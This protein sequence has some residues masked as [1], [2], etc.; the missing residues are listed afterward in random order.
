MALLRGSTRGMAVV[1]T[2][3]LARFLSPSQFGLYG[4]AILV[5]GLLEI[6]TETGINVVL[7]Q[8]E[9]ETDEYISTAWVVSFIRGILISLLIL[10]LAPFIA[11]FFSSPTALNLIRFSS[12]I[13]LVRGFINPSIVKFQKELKFNKEFWFRSSIFLV[14]VTFAILLGILT[15]SEYALIWGMLAAALTEVVLSFIVVKPTPSLTLE[16]EKFK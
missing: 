2:I 4:I 5:L 11:S 15:G 13:P 12:L 10:A 9:E 14:D 1:K 8:E 7:I 6:L 3:V 16:K